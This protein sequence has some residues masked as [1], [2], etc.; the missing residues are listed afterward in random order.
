MT[1]NSSVTP[2]VSISVSSGS[3]PTCTGSSVTFSASPTN[4]GTT[5]AYQW[6]VNGGNVGTNSTTFTSSSLISGDDVS[7]V[8]TSNSSCAS[9]PTATSSLITLT[10]NANP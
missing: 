1:V 10:V 8:L 6:K 9:T 4:G 3:N 2:A 7:C 5:P